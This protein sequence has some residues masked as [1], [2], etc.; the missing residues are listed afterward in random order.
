MCILYRSLMC[1]LSIFAINFRLLSSSS[2]LLL[3]RAL[4]WQR[5]IWLH[6]VSE[7]KFN[8]HQMN[9]RLN[10]FNN[11]L[12]HFLGYCQCS[13]FTGSS[14]Q[15]KGLYLIPNENNIPLVIYRYVLV[16]LPCGYNNLDQFS[17]YCQCSPFSGQV[18]SEMGLYNLIPE[19][20]QHSSCYVCLSW[21]TLRL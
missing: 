6:F 14:Y 17:G 12:D 7:H 11:L 8:L 21:V 4:L 9:D 13:P 3:Y 2:C 20:G 16:E 18:I 15:W 10:I 19:W 5:L 1:F